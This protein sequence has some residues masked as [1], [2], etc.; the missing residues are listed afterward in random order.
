MPDTRRERDKYRR[1]SFRE[2]YGDELRAFLGSTPLVVL[3]A[4]LVGGWLVLQLT[5][6]QVI[7]VTDIKPGDC[8]YI[9]AA[10]ADTDLGGG[11]ATGTEGEVLRALYEQSAERA[12]CDASHSHEVADAWLIDAPAGAP[13]PG[14]PDLV[15]EHQPRCEAA[16]EAHVGHPVSGSTLAMTA[17]VPTERAWDAGVRTVVCL[18]SNADG[19]FLSGPARGSAR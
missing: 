12:P 15:F 4:A 7:R 1:A 16:F 13:Y 11:R 17:G 2:Q 18:V 10:D 3:V 8:L 5:K 9:R 6:P 14:G 19:S